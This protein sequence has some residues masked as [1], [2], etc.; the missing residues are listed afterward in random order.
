MN[1]K[2]FVKGKFCLPACF[3]YLLFTGT[4]YGQT[5]SLKEAIEK[6]VTNYGI[7][8][9]KGSYAKAY[10]EAI[11]QVKSEYLPNLN[12]SAQQDYGTVNGQNGPL[13]GLGG[14]AVA[15]S[16]LP[17]PQQ[18]WNAAFGALY[19][20]NV[21]WEFYNFGRTKQRINIAKA[22]A[23]RY[24]KDYEQ[25]LFQ[26][27]I[28]ISAAYLNLLA[29]QRL[30]ISQE[31]NLG[32][33]EVFFSNVSTRAKNGL[34]PGVDSTLA[35]AEVSRARILLNQIKE[36]VKV[37]NNELVILLGEQPQ[38]YITDT[39][40]VNK[41]P[42]AIAEAKATS[43]TAGHPVKKYFQS[44]ILQ[45]VE[46]EKF[47]RKEKYPSFTLFGVYQ[48]RGSGFSADYASDQNAFTHN[49]FDGIKPTRQNYLF[50]AGVVWNITSI[51][52]SNKKI[53]FQQLT[54]Q[55]LQE[56]YKAVE[57]ELKAREDAANAR[58]GYA[59]RNFN[60]APVQVNAAQQAYIQRLTLYN[61][62]LANLTDVTTVLFTLNRAETDRDIA[63]TNVWQAL[64]LKAAATGNFNLFINE[65]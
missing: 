30:L 2:Y 48:T 55:G 50:G 34:L 28:K 37:Q 17:L 13:Y 35:L 64:L 25:E 36:Q 23:D 44:R 58:I 53:S 9:A 33:A 47:Y 22:E 11:A 57:T 24:Q 43:D 60:E 38:D 15:S 49:Y 16:G 26:Q 21:N 65:F 56:E 62:G 40:F 59:I 8:K 10:K 6:G 3:I 51:T 63:F 18:N 32:R 52:R 61:N 45:S 12:L 14:L 1:K 54:T 46:Q 7:V 27:K 41:I 31:K 42:A 4:A 29:S 20:V 5:L 19:L 39:T